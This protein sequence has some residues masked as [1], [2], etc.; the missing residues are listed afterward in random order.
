MM[1]SDKKINTLAKKVR[2]HYDRHILDYILWE[3]YSNSCLIE[4]YEKLADMS[5]NKAEW[6]EFCDKTEAAIKLA[7]GID[8][9]KRGRIIK[10]LERRFMLKEKIMKL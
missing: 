6:R 10:H 4:E 8:P 2:R 3:M 5:E 7:F 9:K 1:P